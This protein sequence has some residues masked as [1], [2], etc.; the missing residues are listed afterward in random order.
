MP[1]IVYLYYYFYP[2]TYNQSIYYSLERLFKH[3]EP[4]P[5]PTLNKKK[6]NILRPK[7]RRFSC[8]TLYFNPAIVHYLCY[9]LENQ[10]RIYF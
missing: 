7:T 2:G 1:R 5:R 9:L 10:Q 8:P 4:K 3:L 6:E